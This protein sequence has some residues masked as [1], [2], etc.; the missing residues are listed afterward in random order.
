MQNKIAEPPTSKH[1]PAAPV[2]PLINRPNSENEWGSFTA[3]PERAFAKAYG[4]SGYV[5][6]SRQIINKIKLIAENKEK[7][8]WNFQLKA[9]RSTIYSPE[10]KYDRNDKFQYRC[11]CVIGSHMCSHVKAAFDWLEDTYGDNYFVGL[12]DWGKEKAKL[13]ELYGLKPDDEESKQIEFYTDHYGRLQMKAPAWLWGKNAENDI[14]SFKKILAPKSEAHD[15]AERPKLAKEAIIDFET[16]FLFNLLSQHFKTGFELETI[17]VFDKANGKQFK[18]LSIHNDANL[19]L[20]KELPDDVYNLLLGLTD[21]GVKKYLTKNGHGYV[22]NYANPWINLSESTAQLL[23]KYY[24]GQLE[25]LW[26]YLC[27]NRHIYELRE[28]NFSNKNIKP[29]RLSADPVSLG[30]S[31]QEDERFITIWQQLIKN[32]T[33]IDAKNVQIHAAGIFIIDDVC[34]CLRMSMTWISSNNLNTVLSKYPLPISF[35]SSPILFLPFKRNI[36]FTFRHH[37]N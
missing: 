22:G 36:T 24:L 33:V 10:I 13:L 26:P 7:A 15:F 8:S 28:G 17:K 27:N 21:E 30:F 37:S 2:I 5:S 18:K 14:T 3:Q 35:L 19:A 20:L 25:K 16:G 29:A 23:H 31:V 32:E 6:S 11:T 34:I 9:D 4:L 1:P 12:K